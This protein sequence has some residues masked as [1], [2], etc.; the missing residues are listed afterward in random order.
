MR[1]LNLILFL[2]LGIGIVGCNSQKTDD[3]SATGGVPA[4]LFNTTDFR[5][6]LLG[7]ANDLAERELAR[8]M[9][10]E[11]LYRNVPEYFEPYHIGRQQIIPVWVK[12]YR[13]FQSY[14]IADIYRSD[15]YLYPMVY[16]IHYIYDYMH[17][18]PRS[19]SGEKNPKETATNDK[20]FK[21]SNSSYLIRRYRC[22]ANGDYIGDLPEFAPRPKYEFYPTD[23][24][25][26]EINEGIPNPIPSR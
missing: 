4:S 1:A 18:P 3:A 11:L 2:V 25:I 14:E 26:P 9:A 8:I 5:E 23:D 19:M 6:M 21:I 24:R 12:Q 7:K 13:H 10:A 16:E 22:D 17:T 15:S 20:D